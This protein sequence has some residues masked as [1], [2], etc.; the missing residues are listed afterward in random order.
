MVSTALQILI[1]GI[2]LGGIYALIS[3]GLALIVG[4]MKVINFA[5][6]EFLM[7]TMY[8]SYWL[9]YFWGVN[10]Y[11]SL[12]FLIPIFFVIGLLVQKGLIQRLIGDTDLAQIF[13][14]V[15]LSIAMQNGALFLWTADF[16]GVHTALGVESLNIFGYLISYSRLLIL[17]VTLLV[18]FGLLIFLKKTFMGKA[19]RATAQN[20]RA[21][22]LMGINVNRVY[23]VAFGIGSVCV[24][25]AGAMLI[26]IYSVFPTVGTYFVIIAFV[27]VV[28]GGMG[29]IVGTFFA[30]LIIGLIETV[31]GYFLAPRLGALCVFIFF[32]LILLFRPA[33]IRITWK[34]KLAYDQD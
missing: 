32:V 6:G 33:G 4:V 8:F 28:L 18:M 3:M 26:P 23:M 14:T 13:A 27:V 19:M 7:L 34:G 5:H 21:A 1:N 16:R 20:R 17:A 30:G 11:L 9:Y 10:P 15:G 31:G 2:L 29:D 22:W 24:A 25:I 12:V